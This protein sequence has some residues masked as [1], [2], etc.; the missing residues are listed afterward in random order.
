MSLGVPKDAHLG[1][2]VGATRANDFLRHANR[3]GQAHDD[4]PSPRTD[5]DNPERLT[6]IYGLGGSAAFDALAVYQ[7]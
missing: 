1:A 3:S 5:P 6:G 4:R 7:T 2:S